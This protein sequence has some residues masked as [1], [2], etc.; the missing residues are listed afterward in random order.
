M[1]DG[2][3]ALRMLGFTWPTP[4]YIVGALLFGTAGM[5]AYYVGKRRNRNTTRWLGL[6]LM[7]YPYVVPGTA[8]LYAIGLALSAGAWW[9][10]RE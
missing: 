6:A 10:L 5:F 2:L 3:D 8:A 9:A 1:Q 7:L 4:A